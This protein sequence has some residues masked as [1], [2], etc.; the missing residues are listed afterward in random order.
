MLKRGGV[1]EILVRFPGGL[2]VIV[3]EPVDLEE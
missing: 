1:L 2:G 3:P